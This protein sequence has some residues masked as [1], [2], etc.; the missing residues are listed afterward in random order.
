MGY[1]EMAKGRMGSAL[2]HFKRS[3]QCEP[4]DPTLLLY[5]AE[6]DLHRNKRE[7]AEKSVARF[8]STGAD[9]DLKEY[10]EGLINKGPYNEILSQAPFRK[11]VLRMLARE[12]RK[13]GESLL[14]RAEMV[15][16]AMHGNPDQLEK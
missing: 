15:L 14:N 5:L 4:F 6:T 7:N 16:E 8:A 10:V 9:I 3:L 13:R 11:E 12:Y 1:I 2:F